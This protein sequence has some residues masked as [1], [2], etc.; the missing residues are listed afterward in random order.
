[1]CRPPGLCVM[2]SQPGLW[3]SQ[4]GLRPSQPGLRVDDGWTDERKISAFYRTL[5]PIRTA[6]VEEGEG[7][8]GHL[9]GSL[10]LLLFLFHNMYLSKSRFVQG[11]ILLISRINLNDTTFSIVNLSP[12]KKKILFLFLSETQ[13]HWKNLFVPHDCRLQISK[14]LHTEYWWNTL[15]LRDYRTPAANIQIRNKRN[16]RI[17]S[18]AFNGKWQMANWWLK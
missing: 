4:P 16:L 6:Q 18:Y 8:G 10:S 5:S 3:P 15:M 1:M 13:Q 17:F 14:R 2:A 7:T 12:I 11:W 9:T